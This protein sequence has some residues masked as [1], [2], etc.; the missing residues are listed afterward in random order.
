MIVLNESV[1]NGMFYPTF[2]Q[3]TGVGVEYASLVWM[4]KHVDGLDVLG[5]ADGGDE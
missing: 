3:W 2:R 5:G 4:F 1:L